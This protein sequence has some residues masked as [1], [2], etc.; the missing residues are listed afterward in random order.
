MYFF[1]G[2][3]NTQR[4]GIG[5]NFFTCTTTIG[6]CDGSV[7]FDGNTFGES[8]NSMTLVNSFYR[9]VADIM[10]EN[11]DD[12]MGGKLVKWPTRAE[13]RF[14]NHY[15]YVDIHSFWGHDLFV[16]SYED[17][18]EDTI[19]HELIDISSAIKITLILDTAVF[20]QYEIKPLKV[21]RDSYKH[22]A[23][24]GDRSVIMGAA[25]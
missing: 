8:T 23:A 20:P 16:N 22:C 24:R 12:V 19:V 3:N 25:N 17:E 15:E 9:L 14:Q 18:G 5:G 6:R 4:N 10:D 13:V 7:C 2:R 11:F 21:L 1:G